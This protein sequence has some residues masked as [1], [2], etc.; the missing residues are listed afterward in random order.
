ML[1]RFLRIKEKVLLLKG[2]PN[3]S[4]STDLHDPL[5]SEINS[6]KKG[7]INLILTEKRCIKN[8][9]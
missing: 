6:S 3:Y 2:L 7:I 5:K 8:E 9:K 4:F 1:V